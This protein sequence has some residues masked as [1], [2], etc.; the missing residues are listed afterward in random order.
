MTI[1]FPD[2]ES[3]TCRIDVL[4]GYPQDLP[5]DP[6]E[7]SNERADPLEEKEQW[8]EWA[9]DETFNVMWCD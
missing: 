6:D 9:E 5:I 1:T 3:D 8:S 2:T 4:L 7:V